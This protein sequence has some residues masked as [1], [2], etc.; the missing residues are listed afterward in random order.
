MITPFGMLGMVAD[1]SHDQIGSRLSP[2]GN[3]GS[4]S[5][6]WNSIDCEIYTTTTWQ[7]DVMVQKGKATS[8]TTTYGALHTREGIHVGSSEADLQAAYGNRLTRQE[9]PYEG[10]DYFVWAKPDRGFKFEVT[11]GVVKGISSGSKS[12]EY[13]EGCL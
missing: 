6:D 10:V 8:F 5:T 7:V 11:N 3:Y 4:Q 13:V 12:I 2:T 1:M 9:N